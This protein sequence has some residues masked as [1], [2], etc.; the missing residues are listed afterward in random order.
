[1]KSEFYTRKAERFLLDEGISID[2]I[3][4]KMAVQEKALRLAFADI[5][6]AFQSGYAYGWNENNNC[7]NTGEFKEYGEFYEEFTKMLEA[8]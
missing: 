3:I 6:R 4:G 2:G 1:M 5:E 8:E 7:G